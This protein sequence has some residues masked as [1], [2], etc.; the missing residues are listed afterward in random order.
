[1][2]YKEMAVD[3]GGWELAKTSPQVAKVPRTGGAVIPFYR[4][5]DFKNIFICDNVCNL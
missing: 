3:G 1:M 2:V 5:R 4:E